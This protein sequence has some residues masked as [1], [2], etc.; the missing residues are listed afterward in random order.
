V[1]IEGSGGALRDQDVSAPDRLLQRARGQPSVAWQ[2]D[3]VVDGARRTD[4]VALALEEKSLLEGSHPGRRTDHSRLPLAHPPSAQRLPRQ[5]QTSDALAEP[6]TLHRC[7]RRHG[8][9]RIGKTAKCPPGQVLTDVT[10][11]QNAY[12]CAEGASA[13]VIVP[14]WDAFRALD[15]ARI[16]DALSEPIIVDLRNIYSPSDMRKRGFRYFSVGRQ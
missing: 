4:A 9:S 1:S 10:F 3:N 5:T 16:K 13:L 15:L 12:L 2:W 8:F 14:E 11:C 7:L 6:S